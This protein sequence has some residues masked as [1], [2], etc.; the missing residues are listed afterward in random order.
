MDSLQLHGIFTFGDPH[1]PEDIQVSKFGFDPAYFRTLENHLYEL[2][3]AVLLIA[4]DLTWHH[5]MQHAAGQ[6]ERLHCLPSPR[7]Y[8]VEGNH[9]PWFDTL[10]NTYDACQKKAQEMFSSPDF[11][12]IGGRADAFK[13]SCTSIDFIPRKERADEDAMIGICG[14]RGY[15]RDQEETTTDDYGQFIIQRESLKRAL[16]ALEKISEEQSTVANICMLHHPATHQFFG[17]QE[18]DYEMF[19]TI[20]EYKIVG[21]VIFA[22][23][24]SPHLPY[25]Y[26]ELYNIH[27]YCV[28]MEKM[29]FHAARVVLRRN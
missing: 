7:K 21:T 10:D 15:M 20:R 18:Q 5:D 3:P 1:L 8:F 26:K 27:L 24:H 9:D 16:D 12:Y 23:V 22:H 11:Y 13:L 19:R 4:G 28:P 6:I 2:Q 29:E 25:I 14:T 17:Q